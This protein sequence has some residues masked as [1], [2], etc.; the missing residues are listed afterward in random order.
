M[1]AFKPGFTSEF[2]EFEA[3]DA[4]HQ[5]NAKTARLVESA[6]LALTA[7]ALCSSV[8]I[9]GTSG[10]TLS[11]FNT[12]HLRNDSILSLWPAKFDLRPTVALVV[13]SAIVV[14]ASA[15]SLAASKVSAVSL[16]TSSSTHEHDTDTTLYRY[17][18]NLLSTARSLSSLQQFASSPVSSAH[19]SSTAS[20]LPTLYH[21]YR[22]G[23]VNGPRST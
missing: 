4:G 13:C 9:L 20:T 19:P 6:R 11:V 17:E 8:I 2:N 22:A 23:A 18:T 1:A 3:P 21:H 5:K 15:L 7:L 12:T 10:D 16:A 14:F